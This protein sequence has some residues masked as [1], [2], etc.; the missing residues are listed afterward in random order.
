MNL[1]ARLLPLMLLAIAPVAVA[2]SPAPRTA[3]T[4]PSAGQ[5]PIGRWKFETGMVNL[6]CKLS[7]EMQVAKATTTGAY[8]CK[9][10]AVQSC[11]GNPPLEF[12]VQQGCVATQTGSQVTITSKVEKILSVKPEAMFPTVK[13][14]YAADNFEVTLNPAG[15]EMRGMFHSLS[16]ATVRFWRPTGD[17]VS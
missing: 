7:G 2:Q 1:A 13:S 10:I 5:T 11:T 14:G 16:Q 9:F 4:K 6:N 17:L 8:S 15:S 12:Q 3:P